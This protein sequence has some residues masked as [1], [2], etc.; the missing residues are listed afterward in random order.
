[1]SNICCEISLPTDEERTLVCCLSSLNLEKYDEWKDTSLVK[2]LV[3]FLDNVIQFFIDF[4]NDGALKKAK[5]SAKRERA[6]GIGA[7]GWANYLQKNMIPFEGGGVGS[8][9]HVTHK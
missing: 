5:F 6:I 1:G 4:G 8:A 9:L 2:D 3:V 7:M